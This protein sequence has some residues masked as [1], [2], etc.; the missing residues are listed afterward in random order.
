M[1]EDDLK[2]YF[3]DEEIKALVEE[4]WSA[5]FKTS[6]TLIQATKA[7]GFLDIAILP[8]PNIF[9]MLNSLTIIDNMIDI[10][11]PLDQD[12][13]VNSSVNLLN[14]KQQI[15]NMEMIASAIK[16]QNRDAYDA[17]VRRLQNQAQL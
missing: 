3:G 1:T 7:F 11:L 14:A 12:G 13:K 5:V 2:Q 10:I 6:N 16:D 9:Q 15:L 4:L 8:N 17:A